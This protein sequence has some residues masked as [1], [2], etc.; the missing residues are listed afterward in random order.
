V[1]MAEVKRRMDVIDDTVR[2]ILCGDDEC[3]NDKDNR[4]YVNI[5]SGADSNSDTRE[6]FPRT[7]KRVETSSG[8]A[9]RKW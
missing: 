8:H 2:T 4:M 3:N 5:G 9:V 1:A 6:V 7:K